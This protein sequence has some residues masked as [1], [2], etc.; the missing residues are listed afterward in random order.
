MTLVKQFQK[1]NK[2]AFD[3]FVRRYQDRLFRL[4]CLYLDNSADAEDV[5][6]EV[7]LRA[8]KGL[9]RF[10]F[11]S[12][13]FT[14][15][16]RVL[17]NVCSEYNRKHKRH[18]NSSEPASHIEVAD[19][20]S[21]ESDICVTEIRQLVEKLPRR[22]RDVIILRIFE[23]FSIE[24]TARI[25]NCRPGTVKALQSKAVTKLKDIVEVNL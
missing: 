24:Q 7:F 6:Q 25:M 8:Y 9:P 17:K 5:T 10:A 2:H 16:F 4:A 19:P 14:W 15:M 21:T 23:G 20:R 18:S 1:G 11:K 22:Q 3:E 13:P 12:S